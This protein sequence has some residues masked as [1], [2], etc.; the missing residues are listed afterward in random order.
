M[1]VYLPVKRQKRQKNLPETWTQFPS[2]SQGIFQSLVRAKNLIN[3]ML[4]IFDYYLALPED[5]LL[6][7]SSLVVKYNF[8]E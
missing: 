2:H 1:P 4:P 3:V 8:S 6:T 5:A 7:T